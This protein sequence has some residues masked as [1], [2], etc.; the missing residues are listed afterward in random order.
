LARFVECQFVLALNGGRVAFPALV[1][2]QNLASV[3]DCATVGV[4][5]MIGSRLLLLQGGIQ[6]RPGDW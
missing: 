1:M 2:L 4:V 6:C 3:G 5:G